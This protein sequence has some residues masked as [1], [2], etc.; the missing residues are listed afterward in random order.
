MNTASRMEVSKAVFAVFDSCMHGVLIPL[1]FQSLGQRGKIQISQATANLI[2]E[3]DRGHWMS[4]RKDKIMAKGKGLLTTY[5]VDPTKKRGSSVGSGSGETETG[6]KAGTLN[7]S[8]SELNRPF[9]SVNHRL[10]EWMVDLLMDDIK[11]IVSAA[12][13]DFWSERR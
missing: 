1:L 12:F 7:D 10:I 3:A 8:I 4:P 2:M 6:S 11:K 13:F 5:F 9:K